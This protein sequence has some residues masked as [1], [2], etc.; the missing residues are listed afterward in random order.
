MKF[1]VKAAAC[2]S[3]GTGRR[4]KRKRISLFFKFAVKTVLE[5][6]YS[7]PQL[8]PCSYKVFARYIV[9]V[10][11]TENCRIFSASVAVTSPPESEAERSFAP[12]S[13]IFPT[14]L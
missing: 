5:I 1:T 12:A 8:K 14:A 2:S 13:L 10:L 4:L 9:A 3:G 11:P 6:V 7:D